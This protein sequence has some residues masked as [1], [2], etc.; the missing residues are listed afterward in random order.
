[1]AK[2]IENLTRKIVDNLVSDDNNIYIG[3]DLFMAMNARQFGLRILRTGQPYRVENGR[4]MRVISG[5]AHSMVG[6]VS[7]DFE[8]GMIIVIPANS[9]FEIEEIDDDFNIQTFSFRDLPQETAFKECTVFHLNDEDWQLTGKYL[10]LLWNTVKRNPLSL[11]ALRALQSALL[12]ELHVIY[13]RESAEQ[14]GHPIGRREDILRRFT[15]LVNEYA[16]R[17]HVIAF[18]ADRL[19][20]TPNYLGTVIREAS[21]QTV[22]QWIH[23]YIIQQAKLQ[24]KY[25]DQPIWQIAENLNFANPSFFCKFFKHETGMTP[26][27]YRNAAR[28]S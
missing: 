13:N 7:Y 9:I 11:S 4:V 17:E 5:R 10:D 26:G 27:E 24:L 23:R 18:Y 25:S 14:S 6:M 1:M 20:L 3:D 21:G 2:T 19:C 8:A 12:M 15:A 16:A 22:M 28:Q